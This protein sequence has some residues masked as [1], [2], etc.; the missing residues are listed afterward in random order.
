MRMSGDKK[1]MQTAEWILNRL[2]EWGVHRIYGYP[3]DGINAFLGALARV[4]NHDPFFVQTRH[5]EM[6]AFMA[7]AHSKFTGEIGVCLAT[8]GPG[9]IH[10][11]YGPYD[12]N[13]DNPAGLAIVR[14]QQRPTGRAHYQQATVLEQPFEDC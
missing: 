9:A 3:G 11:I 8:G 13:P 4:E 6:A 5:E 14:P 7:C 2:T 1:G 10:L 12:A